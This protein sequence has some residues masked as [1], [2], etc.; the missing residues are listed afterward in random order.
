[1]GCDS[2]VC[3]RRVIWGLMSSG[4]FVGDVGEFTLDDD[5]QGR[6]CKT[7][8]RGRDEAEGEDRFWGW[9]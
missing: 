6:Y 7:L 2:E 4:E 1:M 9:Q 5:A 3:F 8:Q